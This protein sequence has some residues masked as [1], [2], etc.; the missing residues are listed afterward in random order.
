MDNNSNNGSDQ[1]S[2]EQL[3]KWQYK[4][5]IAYGHF[6]DKKSPVQS[7]HRFQEDNIS[8]CYSSICKWYKQFKDK[9]INFERKKGQGRK[10]VSD[11]RER[12]KKVEDAIKSNRYISFDGLET[13]TGIPRG[14][15]ENIIKKELK[16]KKLKSIW[17][18]FALTQSQKNQRLKWCQDQIE[19]YQNGESQMIKY[20]ITGDE[21]WMFFKTC[22]SGNKR[23]WMFSDEDYPRLPKMKPT[24]KKR[25][26]CIFFNSKGPVQISYQ[27][28][29]DTFTSV[30]YIQSL[31]EAA[32]NLSNFASPKIILHQDN[33]AVHMSNICKEYYARNRIQLMGHPAYSPDLA[34]CDFWLFKILKKE[35]RGKEFDN[36]DDLAAAVYEY[37]GS[38]PTE[39]YE[40]CFK[41]WFIRMKK[42]IQANGEYFEIKKRILKKKT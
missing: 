18:P 8:I 28:Q 3:K 38:I 32:L 14:S 7:Y 33:C 5:A 17:V 42:C 9:K 6:I 2:R 36:E 30:H 12:L 39:E 11:Y 16:V 19:L 20:I 29:N 1:H 21:T 26:Y 31:T 24:V 13:E 22:Y 25:M 27:S 23:R 41:E 4:K 35:F 10:K 40:K 34:P 37:L 15:I